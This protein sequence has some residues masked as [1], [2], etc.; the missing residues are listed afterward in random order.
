MT[1]QVGSVGGKLS[2]TSAPSGTNR[3]YS[4]ERECNNELVRLSGL[5]NESRFRDMFKRANRANVSFYPINPAGLRVFDSL[6]D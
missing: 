6:A 5:E 4:D 2:T 1:P 3:S